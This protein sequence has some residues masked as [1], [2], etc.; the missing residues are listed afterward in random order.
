MAGLFDPLAIRDLIL[1]R[2]RLPSSSKLRT[3]KSARQATNDAVLEAGI[4][5]PIDP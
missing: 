1:L 4:T 2:A 3:D 5:N